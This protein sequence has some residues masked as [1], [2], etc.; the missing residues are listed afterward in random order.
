MD[1]DGQGVSAILEAVAMN[2]KRLKPE[3]R[4]VEWWQAQLTWLAEHH[5]R[6]A[7]SR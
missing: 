3:G 7:P 6:L 2:I 1:A 4:H 5:A